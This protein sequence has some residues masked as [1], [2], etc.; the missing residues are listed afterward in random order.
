MTLNEYNLLIKISLQFLTQKYIPYIPATGLHISENE[1]EIVLKPLCTLH[2]AY[3]Y[4]LYC[5][6]IGL[7]KNNGNTNNNSS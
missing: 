5:T 1:R 7:Q 2:N 4:N 3:T 6:Y